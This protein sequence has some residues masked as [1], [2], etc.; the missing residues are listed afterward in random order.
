[1][2]GSR[3]SLHPCF[4]GKRAVFFDAGFTLI[5]P[6]ESIADVYLREARSMGAK[7]SAEEFSL[8]MREVWPRLDADY[9]SRYPDLVS[10][11][12]LERAAW[13]AFTLEIARPFPSLVARHAEWHACLV[14]YYDRP[15]AWQLTAGAKRLI[16]RL[17][18]D[19]RSIGVLSNWSRALHGILAQLEVGSALDFVLTSVEA[20]R[21]KPHPE[22]F[23]QALRLARADAEDVVHIGDSRTDDVEGARAV[24]IDAVLLSRKDAESL[25]DH[26][27]V[28]SLEDL[29]RVGR[30]DSALRNREEH[31]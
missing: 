12:E 2:T 7:A 16:G 4:A 13:H 9:R 17:R 23:R 29:L 8:R 1:M 3:G 24:G 19:G 10:S 11:D 28:R 6:V 26:P 18:D 30:S 14:A 25:D 31:A 5:E 21:K 22:I 15:Q 27:V 20:G